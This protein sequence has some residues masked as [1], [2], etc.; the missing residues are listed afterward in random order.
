MSDF[1]IVWFTSNP[2]GHNKLG[3]AVHSMCKEAGIEGNNT[4]YSLRATTATRA[5]AKG[6]PDKFV[7]ERTGHRN[8]R[9][10][11]IYQTPC[12]LDKVEISKAFD[13]TSEYARHGK[14]AE[15]SGKV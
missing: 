12:I 5:L 13:C 7:M 1:F 2:V 11:Q 10:L 9:S 14:R 3:T 8:L 6:I 15:S 4:N